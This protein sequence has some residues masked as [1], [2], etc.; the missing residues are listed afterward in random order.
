MPSDRLADVISSLSRALSEENAHIG[1][2]RLLK[3]DKLDIAAAEDR[4]GLSARSRYHC[5]T[6][7]GKMKVVS[8]ITMQTFRDGWRIAGGDNGCRSW[9]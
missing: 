2:A 8:A 5:C 3:S 4:F 9:R 7:A 6:C 1:F